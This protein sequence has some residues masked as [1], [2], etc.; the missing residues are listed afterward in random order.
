MPLAN[1]ISIA[2]SGLPQRT[3]DAEFEALDVSAIPDDAVPKLLYSSPVCYCARL[4]IQAHNLYP[5]SLGPACTRQKCECVRSICPKFGLFNS[6]MPS[7]DNVQQIRMVANDKSWRCSKLRQSVHT[8]NEQRTFAGIGPFL[9]IALKDFDCRA[10][11]PFISPAEFPDHK[12]FIRK[13]QTSL[14]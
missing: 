3:L 6:A 4:T 13:R 5:I 9:G 12:I 2:I 8:R 10:R 7:P 1:F 11:Y 14:E